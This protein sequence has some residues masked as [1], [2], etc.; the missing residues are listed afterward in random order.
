MENR[1][2]KRESVEPSSMANSLVP[3]YIAD[4]RDR[5]REKR[6]DRRTRLLKSAVNSLLI[7]SFASGSIWLGTPKRP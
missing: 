2:E 3:P 4:R 7:K 6:K 5:R 1:G